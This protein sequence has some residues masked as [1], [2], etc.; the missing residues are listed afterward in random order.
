[1]H[2]T[3]IMIPEASRYASSAASLNVKNGTGFA[4]GHKFGSQV[5]NTI[6]FFSYLF[7]GPD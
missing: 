2:G 4:C 6:N 5:R 3:N 1:M 7:K